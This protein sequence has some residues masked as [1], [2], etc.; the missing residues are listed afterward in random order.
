MASSRPPSSSRRGSRSGPESDAEFCGLSRRRGSEAAPHADYTGSPENLHAGLHDGAVACDPLTFAK[1]RAWATGHWWLQGFLPV[2]L[3]FLNCRLE[4]TVEGKGNKT[5]LTKS[6]D[7]AAQIKSCVRSA[8]LESTITSNLIVFWREPAAGGSGLRFHQPLLLRPEQVRYDDQLGLETLSVPVRLNAAQLAQLPDSERQ[9][10]S[11]GLVKL[12]PDRGEQ[13]RV[14]RDGSPGYGLAWPSL[15]S[16]FRSLTQSDS[17]EVGEAEYAHA[18]RLVNRAHVKGHEIRTGPATGSKKHFATKEWGDKVLEFYK[19]GA[20]LRDSWRNFDQKLL[21]EW[22][23]PKNYDPT[24]WATIE[25]RLIAWGGPLARILEGRAPNPDMA[26]ALQTVMEDRRAELARFLE[27]VLTEAFRVP[28]SIRLRWSNQC[29]KGQRI[30]AELV[31]W[32]VQQGS[33]SV[34]T[35]MDDVL[36]ENAL[37]RELVRKREERGQAEDLQPLVLPNHGKGGPGGKPE[38]S[39]PGGRPSS[40]SGE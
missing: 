9:R 26:G 33:M 35:A 5:W 16:V 13:F 17:M 14:W 2:Y 1:A 37:D 40:A 27:P 15:F 29:F 12:D 18:G 21:V 22:I 31:K 10:Y 20:G 38:L 34:R 11:S 7:R 24:K 28:G 36:G 39:A 23:D 30:N 25:R 4:V 19:T 6:A 32:A 8:L 3:S